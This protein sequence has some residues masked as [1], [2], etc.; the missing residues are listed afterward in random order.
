MTRYLLDADELIEF[1]KGIGPA[2]ELM[3][4]LYRRGASIRSGAFG[5]DPGRATGG[6]NAR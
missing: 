4:E 6:S 5:H 2:L 3:S 1:F